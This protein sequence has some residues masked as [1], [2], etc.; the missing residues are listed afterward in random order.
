MDRGY[1]II[2]FIFLVIIVIFGGYGIEDPMTVIAVLAVL[3]I[4]FY[5]LTK[6]AEKIKIKTI[7]FQD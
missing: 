7:S 6:A 2:I 1:Y 3:M 5:F 4:F